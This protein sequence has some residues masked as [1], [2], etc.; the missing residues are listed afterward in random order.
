MKALIVSA[1][2]FEDSELLEPARRLR[3]QGV[4][5]D[6][7]SMRPGVIVGKH[8]Q[9][10]AVD[11]TVG[12]LD[13][14]DYDLLLLPGGEAPAALRRDAAVLQLVRRFVAAGKPVAAICHG[15]QLLAAAGVLQGRRATGCRS[16]ADELR[17]A[18]AAYEDREVVVDEP[19]ITSRRP[20]DLPAFLAA[21]MRRLGPTR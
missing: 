6:I 10:V 17:A 18:G 13:A 21:V 14:A 9:R 12:V 19:L 16:V 5:V 1:D 2:R 20:A 7:A 8:G 4:A 15:P 3:E 11:K